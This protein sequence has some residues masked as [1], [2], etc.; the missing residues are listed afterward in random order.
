VLSGELP[1]ALYVYKGSMNARTVAERAKT[2]LTR[3]VA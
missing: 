3:P 1:A 2:L